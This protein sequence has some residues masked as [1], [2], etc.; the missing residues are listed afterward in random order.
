MVVGVQ[1]PLPAPMICRFAPNRAII[2]LEAL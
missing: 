2:L 1:V